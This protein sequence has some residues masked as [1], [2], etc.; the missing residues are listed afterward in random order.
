MEL[1][2][3]LLRLTVRLDVVRLYFVNGR[4][5]SSVFL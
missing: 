2:I 4:K 5:V 3:K 1:E